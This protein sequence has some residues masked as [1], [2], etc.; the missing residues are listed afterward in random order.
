MRAP[1]AAAEWGDLARQL[2]FAPVADGDVLPRLPL[3]AAAGQV[4]ALIGTNRDEGRLFFVLG[5]VIDVIDEAM[6]ARFAAEYEVTDLSAFGGATPGEVLANVATYAR[7]VRPARQ[8]ADARG[9]TPTWMYRFDGL[10]IADNGG[11]GSCH[12]AEMLGRPRGEVP[13]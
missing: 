8:L 6:L 13:A 11:L 4:P 2:P 5:G 1:G 9:A 3:E 12:A 7:F 10:G